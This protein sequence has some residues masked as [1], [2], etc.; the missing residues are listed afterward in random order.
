MQDPKNPKVPQDLYDIGY[1]FVVINQNHWISFVRGQKTPQT[2]GVGLAKAGTY[3]IFSP[4]DSSYYYPWCINKVQD[5]LKIPQ[6]TR[7]VV[8]KD[9]VIIRD[10]VTVNNTPAIRAKQGATP[11]GSVS[12]QG[13]LDERVYAETKQVPVYEMVPKREPRWGAIIGTTALLAVAILVDKATDGKVNL[14]GLIKNKDEVYE[15]HMKTDGQVDDPLP[16]DHEEHKKT[17]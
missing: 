14:F 12:R 7:S 5:L 2:E 8:K 15:P 10:T 9:T 1:R 11:R 3:F 6:Q 17:G 13:S 4:K 16:S